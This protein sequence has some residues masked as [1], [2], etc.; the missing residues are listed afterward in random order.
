MTNMARFTVGHKKTTAEAAQ[1]SAPAV[2]SNGIAQ[3]VPL[4][5]IAP[6]IAVPARPSNA[7]AHVIRFEL[8]DTLFLRPDLVRPLRRADPE[9]TGRKGMLVGV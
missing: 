4:T 5:A 7:S 1:K 3:L 2:H 8:G 6:K 9:S